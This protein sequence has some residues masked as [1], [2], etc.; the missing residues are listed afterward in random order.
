[1]AANP[2]LTGHVAPFV[3]YAQLHGFHRHVELGALLHGCSPQ[4][5]LDEHH[6]A[7]VTAENNTAVSDPVA[8][9]RV[10]H[11]FD[12]PNVISTRFRRFYL[13][14]F[15]TLSYVTGSKSG[16]LPGM[17]ELILNPSQTVWIRLGA[18]RCIGTIEAAHFPG[19]TASIAHRIGPFACNE[20][21]ECDLIHRGIK[22]HPESLTIG[23]ANNSSNS[24]IIRQ[25]Y[26]HSIA[27]FCHHIAKASAHTLFRYVANCNILGNSGG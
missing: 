10:A 26:C 27:N 9:P 15:L 3:N 21:V 1:M 17:Q 18:G 4:E 13:R 25:T 5:L 19:L 14:L 8:T 23:P 11:Q 20:V 7:K 12:T 2:T 22:L 6:A 16:T 24:G